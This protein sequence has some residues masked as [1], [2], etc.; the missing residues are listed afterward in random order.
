MHT[1]LCKQKIEQTLFAIEQSAQPS[2]LRFFKELIMHVMIS[3]G[4]C[5]D[6]SR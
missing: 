2:P 4:L 3:S 5:R 1:E 6:I